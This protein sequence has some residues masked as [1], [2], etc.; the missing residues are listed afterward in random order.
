M[1]LNEL[2]KCFEKGLIRKTLQSKEKAL[3]SILKARKWLDEA[4]KNF[5][6]KPA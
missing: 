3:K 2:E 5:K 1:E 6:F 4:K